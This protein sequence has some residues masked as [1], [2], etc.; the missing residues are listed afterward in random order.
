MAVEARLFRGCGTIGGHEMSGNR[1]AATVFQEK[2]NAR[3]RIVGLPRKPTAVFPQ[4][5]VL[6][7]L[8]CFSFR[9][10][11]HGRNRSFAACERRK[12]YNRF[13]GGMHV[14]KTLCA[15]RASNCSLKAGNRGAER[16]EIFSK[17]EV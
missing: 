11:C 12:N 17:K 10:R 15:K 3:V 13:S 16:S 4:M 7:D 14:G 9:C 1:Y 5:L 6:V 2:E 8:T